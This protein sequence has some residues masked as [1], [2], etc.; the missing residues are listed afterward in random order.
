MISGVQEWKNKEG[1]VLYTNN[2]QIAIKIKATDYLKKHRFKSEATL[3]NTLDLY[4]SMGK[5]SYSEFESKL[6]E[7][8][9]YEC[10][11]MVRGFISTIVDASKMVNQIIL[12][13]TAFVDKVVRHLPTRRD[14]A[15]KILASYGNSGRSNMVFTILDNKPLSDDQVKKLFWQVLKRT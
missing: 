12:G 9:D 4:F 3:E 13:M 8:F 1:V 2:D 5:P 6:I 15:Q 14:Q 7:T 11:E 10:F